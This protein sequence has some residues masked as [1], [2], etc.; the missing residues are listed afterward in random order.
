R[1]AVSGTI[2]ATGGAKG[3]LTLDDFRL[4]D[5]PVAAQVLSVAGLTGILDVLG[6]EGID[7]QRA[8]VPFERQGPI[9]RF[10]EARAW[11]SAIG[12]RVSG[13]L[14]LKAETLDL[15]GALAPARA[16]NDVLEAIPV[17]GTLM[18]GIEGD[19]FI[20]LNF[21]ATGPTENPSVSVNPLSAITPGLLRDL[22]GGLTTA[23]PVPEGSEGAVEAPTGGD[24]QTDQ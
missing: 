10:L 6:G 5:A 12:L 22:F 7:F 16:I 14:D 24:R 8:D 11:G 20:A 3:Q 9:L 18:T 15:S 4:V 1:M 19:G 2:D 17:L 21:A 23:A 13:Q